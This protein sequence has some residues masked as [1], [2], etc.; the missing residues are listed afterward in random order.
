MDIE[1]YSETG[2]VMIFITSS[3]IHFKQDLTDYIPIKVPDNQDSH[4]SDDCGD[5]GV[6]G[7]GLKGVF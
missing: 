2:K 4:T 6:R 3:A 5:C 7:R 1:T